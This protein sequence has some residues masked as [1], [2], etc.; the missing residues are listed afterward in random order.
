LGHAAAGALGDKMRL[1]E[2]VKKELPEK[3]TR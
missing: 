3:S 2:G 1:D